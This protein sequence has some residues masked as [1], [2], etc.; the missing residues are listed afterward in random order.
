MISKKQLGIALFTIGMIT[1]T[2]V[3]A[4]DW[5]GAGEFSGIGPAQKAALGVGGAIALLGLSL[6][7]LGDRPA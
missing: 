2:A 1:L 3:L 7:P 6:I 5:I 4:V